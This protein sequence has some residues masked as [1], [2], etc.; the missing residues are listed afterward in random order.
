[1]STYR[2]PLIG[3]FLSLLFLFTVSP[4]LA[5]FDVQA[6][7]ERKAN[8]DLYKLSDMDVGEVLDTRLEYDYWDQ[9]NH[10]S[11]VLPA[12]GEPP[13]RPA[14]GEGDNEELYY[15]RQ[16]VAAWSCMYGPERAVDG[17]PST[18]WSEGAP[19]DGDGEMILVRI[20]ES[21]GAE[22]WTGFGLSDRL[23][24][25]NGRPREL[26]VHVL[27][28]LTGAANQ[29]DLTM[30]HLV[31]LAEGEVELKDVNGWQELPLPTFEPIRDRREVETALR[32]FFEAVPPN[33]L[34]PEHLEAPIY[35]GLEITSVYPGTAYNDTLISEVRTTSPDHD[36]EEM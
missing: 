30:G 1:M 29:Y 6:H 31:K 32:T 9:D 4:L 34:V 17:D 28:A 14:D 10:A 3:V 27:Q 5:Q 20:G 35:L 18:A 8:P 2:G 11:S 24:R 25:R 15:W 19:G 21:K 22:I 26:R 7:C 12:E 16:E 13:P 23:H 36:S 33:L